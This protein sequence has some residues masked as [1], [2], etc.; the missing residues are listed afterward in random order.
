MP[1]VIEEMTVQVAVNGQHSNQAALAQQSN[2]G[3][4]QDNNEKVTQ[5]QACLDEV[6]EVLRHQKER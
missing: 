3:A 2:A 5:F 1:I 4:G 6:M